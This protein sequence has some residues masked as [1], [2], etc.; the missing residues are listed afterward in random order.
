M[1]VD[2]PPAPP[3]IPVGRESKL[4]E[5]FQIGTPAG[6]E[7]SVSTQEYHE[8]GRDITEAETQ[9]SAVP[10]TEEPAS[11]SRPA[12][13]TEGTQDMDVLQ[14]R[15]TQE[16]NITTDVPTTGEP[17]TVL[18]GPVSSAQPPPAPAQPTQVSQ[19][20]MNLGDE[21]WE[22]E[23]RAMY[24]QIWANTRYPGKGS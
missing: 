2:D 8:T 16:L 23:K 4:P 12:P 9:D 1:E 18:P 15:L 11:S 6:S 3:M 10:A 19:P 21:E 20:S 17:K 7:I 5:R 24:E 13:P 22:R 14:R